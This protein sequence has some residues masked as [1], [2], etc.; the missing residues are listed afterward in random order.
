MPRSRVV[1]VHLRLSEEQNTCT[2]EGFEE[3]EGCECEK[4]IYEHS[5]ER[6][7]IST[8]CVTVA[9]PC[10]PTDGR[11]RLDRDLERRAPLSNGWRSPPISVD[12][13]LE[14]ATSP[15]KSPVVAASTSSSLS[16]SSSSS[17]SRSSP[18]YRNNRVNIFEYGD[19]MR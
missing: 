13:K 16:S 5:E 17:S 9:F 4:W 14:S 15:G 10:G 3:L 1:W 11:R 7:T 12:G 18:A 6:H 8:A 2:N 19:M